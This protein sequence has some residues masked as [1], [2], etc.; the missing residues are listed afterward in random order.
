[1]MPASD[2]GLD[3]ICE[4]CNKQFKSIRGGK[5]HYP[6]CTKRERARMNLL[7]AAEEVSTIPFT[8][9]QGECS[10]WTVI[11]G[12]DWDGHDLVVESVAEVAG[13]G[14]QRERVAEVA[15]RGRQME[16]MAEVAAGEPATEGVVEL[17][18]ERAGRIDKDAVNPT[19]QILMTDCNL[20]THDTSRR[21]GP[22]QPPNPRMCKY[23]YGFFK[24]E[25][26]VKTHY[27]ACKK[28]AKVR[29]SHQESVT[30][31]NQMIDKT[32]LDTQEC[33]CN[34]NCT[35]QIKNMVEGKRTD[36]DGMWHVAERTSHEQIHEKDD[37]KETS[38]VNDL[39]QIEEGAEKSTNLESTDDVVNQPEAIIQDISDPKSKS[40]ADFEILRSQSERCMIMLYIGK[41]ISSSCRKGILEKNM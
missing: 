21:N 41:E 8:E 38:E 26:G 12:E 16:G 5:T 10:N 6:S 15:E 29:A 19:V 17:A 32:S 3:D 24:S 28:R 1:M 34:N 37:E 11:Q 23:C 4:Y 14:R 22:D 20:K 35:C 33:T 40:Q 18:P 36:G 9:S 13:G 30:D 27:H 25:R 7:S 39:T 31:L 2:N